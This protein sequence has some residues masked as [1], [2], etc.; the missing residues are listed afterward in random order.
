MDTR[1]YEKDCEKIS[2]YYFHNY[3]YF[4]TRSALDEANLHVAFDVVQR[5]HEIEFGKKMV[6]VWGI[7]DAL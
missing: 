5:L 2:G 7:S 6:S 3:P 1:R 4:G